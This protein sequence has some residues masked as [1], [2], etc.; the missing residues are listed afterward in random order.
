V[1]DAGNLDSLLPAEH[2]R[3]INFELAKSKDIEIVRRGS[4]ITV[5][6]TKNGFLN[7]L[8]FIVGQEFNNSTSMQDINY[9]QI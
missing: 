5:G 2:I 8:A 3:N 9:H 6:F 4:K 7:G 1:F